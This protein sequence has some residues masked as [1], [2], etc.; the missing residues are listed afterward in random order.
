MT[1]EV[2]Y[3]NLNKTFS[4]SELSKILSQYISNSKIG[5]L[6]LYRK[7]FVHKSYCTRK[8]ENFLNGNKLCPSDCIPLQEDSNERL[9]FFGD[10][11]LSLIISDYLFERYPNENEGYLTKMR[12]K[13][14]NG[15][16][17]AFLAKKINL[18]EYIMISKQI[19]ENDGRYNSNILEDV[20]EALIA[21]IYL[22]QGLDNAREW[23]I[24]IIETHIDFASLILQN[25]NYKDTFLKFYQQTYSEV[26]RFYEMNVDTKSVNKAKYSV[27]I[28]DSQENII[29]IG[30]GCN[31][32]EAE[33]EAA[34]NALFH[35][36]ILD[37]LNS[38]K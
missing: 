33:N 22:D 4:E 9:E 18:Q 23:V 38:L 5:S 8:N 26:P 3:N 17:L 29:S 21:A 1:A 20:F 32:K 14:V 28:K 25:N 27:C 10:S 12:T 16:M 13:L 31:K 15:R 6:P 35:Y 7:A 24:N 36:G 37:S 2:P 34:K 30:S 11:I 19:E